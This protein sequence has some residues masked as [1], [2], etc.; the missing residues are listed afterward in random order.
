MP[1]S[2]GQVQSSVAWSMLFRL[3]KTHVSIKKSHL[4]NVSHQSISQCINK[5]VRLSVC[6]S[7]SLSVSQSVCLSV[8]LSISLSVCQSVSLSV[9]QSVCLS[10]C[11]SVYPSV[12]SVSRSVGLTLCLSASVNKNL[13]FTRRL[14]ANRAARVRTLASVIVLCSWPRHFNLTQVY[15]WFLANALLGVI[16]WWTSI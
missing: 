13:D 3:D 14:G 15:K 5:S 4:S 1:M 10:V 2:T 12:W 6:P 9:S 8:C 16:L 7:V 11:L